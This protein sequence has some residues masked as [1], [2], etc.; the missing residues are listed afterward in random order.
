M[1]LLL[2]GVGGTGAF[3]LGWAGLPPRGRLG[4]ADL[5]PEAS[6]EFALNGW[7]KV[8]TDGSVQFATPYVEMGQGVHT[9]LALLVAEEMDVAPERVKPVQAPHDAI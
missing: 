4:R 6:G 2:A 5:L 3:V 8:L 1:A 7:I 9:A